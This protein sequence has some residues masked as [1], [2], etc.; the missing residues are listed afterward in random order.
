MQTDFAGYC[1]REMIGSK[2]RGSSDPCF[3]NNGQLPG[4]DRFGRHWPYP[5][6]QENKFQD[7]YSFFR[8]VYR[9]IGK[10]THRKPYIVLCLSRSLSAGMSGTLKKN[11]PVFPQ[12]ARAGFSNSARLNDLRRA[13]FAAFLRITGNRGEFCLKVHVFNRFSR[14]YMQ[15]IRC[16]EHNV[17]GWPFQ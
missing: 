14:E 11:F 17:P 15:A 6:H 13:N 12:W 8:E 2:T 7:I 9:K 5:D 16:S 3:K 10:N 1:T 4:P